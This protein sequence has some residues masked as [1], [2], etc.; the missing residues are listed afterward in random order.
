MN[1]SVC[2]TDEHYE[3]YARFMIEHR[4]D[5]YL[6]AKELIRILCDQLGEGRLFLA[7]NNE[8]KVVGTGCY[9]IG[10]P[11]NNFE[12]KEIV[13]LDTTIMLK[14]Y[15]ASFLFLKGLK[16]VVNDILQTASKV[17]EVKIL[18][19]EQDSYLQRLYGKFATNIGINRKDLLVFNTT[20]ED[21]LHYVM[22]FEKR[23]FGDEGG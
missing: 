15:R 6:D 19:R 17:K 4:R 9:Y 13:L 8:D 11:D 23:F 12:D 2:K 22:K 20:L 7:V 10:T 21:L 16:S 14:E 1:I 5:F 18:V 3:K